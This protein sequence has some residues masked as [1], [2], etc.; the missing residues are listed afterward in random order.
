MISVRERLGSLSPSRAMR[1]KGWRFSGVP[2]EDV[3]EGLANCIVFG[4][5]IPMRCEKRKKE[6]KTKQK[7]RKEK[8]K[9]IY[10]EEN[11]QP[12]E[13][14]RRKPLSFLAIRSTVQPA[15]CDPRAHEQCD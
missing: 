2:V 9:D 4:I 1:M 8:K 7:K 12:C 3:K 11:N 5:Q 6:K 14:C 13:V 10:L 15:G